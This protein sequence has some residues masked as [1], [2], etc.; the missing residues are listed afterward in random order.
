MAGLYPKQSGTE[1]NADAAGNPPNPFTNMSTTSAQVL[2]YSSMNIVKATQYGA[3][4]RCKELIE[5]GYDVNQRDEEDVTLLHWA[6]I[7]NRIEVMKYF[8]SKNADVNAIGGD[9]K[10]TPMHWAARQGHIRI[11]VLLLAHGA[12]PGIID[13]EGRVTSDFS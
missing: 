13:G 2:D 6:A 7:N 3:I 9:L 4:D 10:G 1:I 5:G 12:D 11:V 8:I